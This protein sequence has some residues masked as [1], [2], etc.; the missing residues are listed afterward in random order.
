[1]TAAFGIHPRPWREA[2][3]DMMASLTEQR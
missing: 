2:L 1:L 3:E